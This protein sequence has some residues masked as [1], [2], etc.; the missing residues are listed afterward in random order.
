MKEKK[1]TVVNSDFTITETVYTV[2][3]LEK[4][5]TYVYRVT[6]VNKVGKS[7]VSE[8]SEEIT[9]QK[10]VNLKIEVV[11]GLRD[12]EGREGD[13]VELR[14][15]VK[16]GDGK[17]IVKW[18]RDRGSGGE[19][20][21]EGVSYESRVCRLVIRELREVDE[22]GYSVVVSNKVSKVTSRC[23]V[24]LREA[25]VLEFEGEGYERVD[26]GVY[27]G[28][29]EL[30]KEFGFRVVAK[31]YPVPEL[32]VM[33]NEE[34]Y[35]AYEVVERRVVRVRKVVEG[36]DAGVYVV[37]GVNRRERVEISVRVVVIGEFLLD[38]VFEFLMG[39][40]MQT[41]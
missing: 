40:L 31:G 37:R 10:E 30:G 12:V 3:R 29:V 39:N 34:E 13:V 41:N 36:R 15:V 38:S 11:E 23:S 35:G 1:W 28:R 16:G 2:V 8:E 9:V 24:M 17:E 6:A 26:E 19:E 14:C 27:K 25:L 33:R 7:E 22:G 32:S 4:S 21:R 20:V 5:C 18:Y